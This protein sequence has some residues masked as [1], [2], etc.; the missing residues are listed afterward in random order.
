[1]NGGNTTWVSSNRRRERAKLLC[2]GRY[3]AERF[4]SGYLQ[5]SPP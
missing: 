4:V 3:A 1:M 2:P 5:N